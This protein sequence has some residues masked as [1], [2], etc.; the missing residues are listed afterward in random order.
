M[1]TG[2]MEATA[3]RTGPVS[4][5]YLSFVGATGLSSVGDAAWTIALASTVVESAGPATAGTVLALAGVPRIV[6]L[7]GAGAVADRHGA[8]RVMVWSD[9]ARCVLMAVAAV[10]VAVTGPSVP[11]LFAVA[12]ALGLLG[13]F[14]LPASGALRP[15]L[16]PPEHLV[17]GNA[18]YLIGLRTGQAAGGPVG[19]WLL[20]LGGM[21]VVAAVN[22]VS[23][24]LSAVAVAFC[25]PRREGKAAEPPGDTQD[26]HEAQ[27]RTRLI[28]RVVEGMRYAAG[29]RDLR[30]LLCVVGLVELAGAG[31][32]NVGLVLLADSLGAGA[33]GAGVLLSAFTVGAAAAFLTSLALPVRRRVT[34]V[35]VACLAGQALVLVLLGHVHAVAL[36]AVGYGLM[37]AV[38]AQAS[39][40]L[41]SLIQRSS[42]R[43]MRGR[44]M[45]LMSLLSFTAPLAGNVVM[46]VAVGSFGF[47][48]TLGLHG[49][50]AAASIAVF[51]NSRT[52]R[53]ARLD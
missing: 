38:T 11:V 5:R 18:L 22:A 42:T 41:M 28:T 50:V 8:A 9:L 13:A 49:V 1:P 17:R 26:A 44:V 48:V 4:S 21:V 15:L 33:A 25:R 39:L 45:A 29:H 46:G 16:L 40:V 51:L 24:L 43:E 12:A 14:F 35:L 7:L 53:G 2:E 47:A 36:A 10:A 31:P 37:G 30:L 27:D 34:A 6:A 23:F 52:L 3:A 19:A 32:V 20:G